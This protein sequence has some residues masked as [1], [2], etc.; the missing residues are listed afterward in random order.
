MTVICDWNKLHKTGRN[1]LGKY[2]LDFM[3]SPPNQ[4]HA[5]SISHVQLFA[6]LWTISLQAP[7]SVGFSKQEY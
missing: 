4:N 1:L 6:T 3:Y 5:K 7:L 2:V